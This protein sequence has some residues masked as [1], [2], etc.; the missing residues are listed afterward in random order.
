[1]Y[2]I[3][4]NIILQVMLER[5]KSNDCG[6]LL[7]QIE[8]GKI[9]GY[10]N[11]FLLFSICLTIIN[12]TNKMQKVKDF[13][14]IISTYN[15]LFIYYASISDLLQAVNYIDDLKLDFDDSLVF[16]CMKSLKIDKIISFDK[17]FDKI[18]SI[19]RLEPS[20][21]LKI[22]QNGINERE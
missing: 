15:H 18:P 22:N 4:A 9:D 19:N 7:K 17:H 3:D 6:E 21:L 14:K 8:K 13:L 2:F 11:D 5:E 12:R 1:M 10:I 20:D 16:A